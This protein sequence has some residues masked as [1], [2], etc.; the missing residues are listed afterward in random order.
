MTPEKALN[1]AREDIAEIR[2]ASTQNECDI[3]HS[4][5]IRYS[6]A[7]L[8]CGLIS[9]AQRRVLIAEA[10]LEL[11]SWQESTEPRIPLPN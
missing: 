7:L 10:D 6:R 2:L 5:I 11:A 3:L 8:D 9:A 4:A 1:Y